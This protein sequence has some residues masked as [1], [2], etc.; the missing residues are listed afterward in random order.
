MSFSSNMSL[1][2]ENEAMSRPA[3]STFRAKH[4][5]IKRKK[6]IH[7]KN[8]SEDDV[9]RIKAA[10]EE[11]TGG[12]EADEARHRVTSSVWS[13]RHYSCPGISSSSTTICF[14]LLQWQLVWLF[15]IGRNS[16]L[17]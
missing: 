2:R 13:G 14:W 4:E 6:I 15:L 11:E 1:S 17:C 9:A 10:E 12:G 7:E 8:G 5:E 3:L 16:C